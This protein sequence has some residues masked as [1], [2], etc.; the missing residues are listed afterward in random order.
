MDAQ[1]LDIETH[2]CTIYN[3]ESTWYSKTESVKAVSDAI[4]TF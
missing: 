2:N 4:L 1:I 3:G